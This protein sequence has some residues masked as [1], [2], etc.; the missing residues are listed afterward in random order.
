LS[1]GRAQE[2]LAQA[3]RSCRLRNPLSRAA[4]FSRENFYEGRQ[5]HLR[6]TYFFRR[7][8]YP[9]SFERRRVIMPTR[10][11]PH[12]KHKKKSHPHSQADASDLRVTIG[13]GDW[14]KNR[15]ARRKANLTASPVLQAFLAYGHLH[16]DPRVMVARYPHSLRLTA[17]P[18]IAPPLSPIQARRNDVAA[19]SWS[20][21]PYIDVM[22]AYGRVPYPILFEDIRKGGTACRQK[23]D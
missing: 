13:Y 12:M 14:R 15:E 19:P 11:S 23:T 2:E 8:D 17:S 16:G 5:R 4:F 1:S 22:L 3:L 7:P 21:T 20:S 10:R 18:Y 9:K 6:E